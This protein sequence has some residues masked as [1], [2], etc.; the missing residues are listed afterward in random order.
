MSMGDCCVPAQAGNSNAPEVEF[1]SLPQYAGPLWP[2]Y[3]PTTS[4]G[5]AAGG[6]STYVRPPPHVWDSIS[7]DIP[8]HHNVRPQLILLL[9]RHLALQSEAATIWTVA[10][11]DTVMTAT[12]TTAATSRDASSYDSGV[13]LA[14]DSLTHGNAQHDWTAV[15]DGAS[16]HSLL[17]RHQ[18][19]HAPGYA[20]AEAVQG[21][22]ALSSDRGKISV[23]L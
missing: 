15:G 11:I 14:L 16:Q 3:L 20:A 10:T 19:T 18:G 23:H 2:S 17:H 22:L 4:T 9:L 13:R 6:S 5:A 12:T 7:V 8:R 1:F 21:K